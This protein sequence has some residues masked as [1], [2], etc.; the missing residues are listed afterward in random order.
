[1]SGCSRPVH[2]M[3]KEE[4]W[5][6]PGARWVAT[7]TGAFPV[8]RGTPDRNALRKADELL[9]DGLLVGLFP[10]GTRSVEGL[11]RGFEASA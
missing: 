10:E 2:F 6:V 8:R 1:M 11:T 3:A 5:E 9:K 7:Q 4:I